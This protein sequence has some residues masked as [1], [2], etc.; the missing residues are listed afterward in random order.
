[1]M[2]V[3]RCLF[4]SYKGIIATSNTYSHHTG[5]F[6]AHSA[7]ERRGDSHDSS[8]AVTTILDAEKRNEQHV[9]QLSAGRIV[10]TYYSSDDIGKEDM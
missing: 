6:A 3:W 4:A 8:L 1:M 10:L 5:C 2:A 9:Q 7:S